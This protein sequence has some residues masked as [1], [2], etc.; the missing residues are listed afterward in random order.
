MLK[1]VRITTLLDFGGQ[2]KQYISFTDKPSI[3][4]NNYIFAAIGHG[5][6]AE[7]IIRDRGFEVK[8]FNSNPGIKNLLNIIYLY[9]W[10]RKIKPDIVHT[11]AAEANFHGIIA[12]KLAGV[13]KIYAEEIGLPS[14]SKYAQFIFR[15]LYKLTNKVICVSE[16]VKDNLLQLKE[17]ELNKGIVIYNPVSLPKRH[18]KI[19]E[20]KFQIVYVGRLE[21]VKN[22]EFLI[23]ALAKLSCIEHVEL[24]I[25]GEGR[26]RKN[27]ESLIE[28]YDLNNRITLIGFNNEPEIFVSQAD[29]FVLPSLSEGFGIAV[30]ESM[31]Q[32][33]PCLC[34]RVGGIPEFITNDLNGWLFNPDNE[35]DFLNKLEEIIQLPIEELEKVGNNGY[36]Y[37]IQN[38]TVEHYISKL[39]LVYSL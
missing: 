20:K 2:E 28:H 29:L 31:L 38:F 4:S 8:I 37:A 15:F 5:G 13:K 34:S 1:I 3:L 33:I 11:A 25:V 7:R 19:K 18:F 26:E 9:R 27:I 17:I 36:K 6:Y 35:F 14:H 24:K 12:A 16:A 22:V 23:H 30:V 32:G 10:F 21:K 39:E